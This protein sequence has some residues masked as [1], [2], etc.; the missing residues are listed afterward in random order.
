MLKKAGRNK[1]KNNALFITIE[2]IELSNTLDTS[3]ENIYQHGY[4]P[5]LNRFAR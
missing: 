3:I 4:I 1:N 2:N 5:K